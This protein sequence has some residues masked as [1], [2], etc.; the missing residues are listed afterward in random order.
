MYHKETTAWVLKYS[1]I[2]NFNLVGY[3]DVD[4]AR[5][6]F[7]RKSTTD[8]THLL[9][10]C[11]IFWYTKKQNFVVLST[12]EVVY[13]VDWIVLCTGTPDKTTVFLF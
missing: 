4:Y 10:K 1:K 6:L 7:D 11:S 12:T 9:K 13:V 2:S 8:M 5:Y 3:V